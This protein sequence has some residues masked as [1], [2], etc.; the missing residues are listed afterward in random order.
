MPASE[1]KRWVTGVV[2]KKRER[3]AME[4]EAKGPPI[5]RTL[6]RLRAWLRDTVAGREILKDAA[7]G[8]L[9]EECRKCERRGPVP[10]VLVVVRRLGPLPGVEVYR[11]PGVH[12]RMEE[13]VDSCDDAA[14][15]R[16]VDDLL[17]AQLPKYWKHLVDC[18]CESM[19]FSGLTA[20][21]RMDA[22]EVLRLLNELEKR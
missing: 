19:V 13:L 8:L 14:V 6:G 22:L 12:L 17:R 3:V 21:R 2:R 7:I 9:E 15:E 5:P 11:E 20:T 1:N 10:R 18:R 4:G 16:L